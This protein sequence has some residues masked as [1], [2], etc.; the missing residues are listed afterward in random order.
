MSYV[1]NSEGQHLTFNEWSV[2]LQYNIK[3]HSQSYV[4]QN[5]PASSNNFHL[6]CK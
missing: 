1:P 2:R 6:K 5:K 4:Q 3:I